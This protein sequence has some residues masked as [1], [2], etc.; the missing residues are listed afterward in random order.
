[1]HGNYFVTASCIEHRTIR[2]IFKN[3]NNVY[4]KEL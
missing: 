4:V 3:K 1:M 2:R